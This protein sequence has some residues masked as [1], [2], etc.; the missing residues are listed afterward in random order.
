MRVGDVASIICQALPDMPAAARR[1][2]FE[3]HGAARGD[4]RGGDALQHPVGGRG[5]AAGAAGDGPDGGDAALQRHRSGA[6]RPAGAVSRRRRRRKLRPVA[7]I[8]RHVI[9]RILNPR[10]LSQIAFYDV[11]SSICQS[12]SSR[13]LCTLVYRVNWDPM[14]WRAISGSPYRER[15]REQRAAR[16]GDHGRRHRR[17]RRRVHRHQPHV[18]RVLLRERRCTRGGPPERL[19]GGSMRTSTQTEIGRARMTCL[20]DDCLA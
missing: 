4:V 17:R 11:A 19:A 13:A 12:L 1:P 10:L 8:A 6:P 9:Q 18:R 15:H 20:Q 5:P 7:D 16:R 2:H 14:T 3:A